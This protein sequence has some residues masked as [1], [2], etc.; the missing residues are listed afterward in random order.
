MRKVVLCHLREYL[1]RSHNPM[2][3]MSVPSRISD[4][5]RSGSLRQSGGTGLGKPHCG[6]PPVP[7]GGYGPGMSKSAT[8]TRD[9]AKLA[10]CAHLPVEGGMAT[11][12]F[13]M[14]L[15]MQRRNTIGGCPSLCN[16]IVGMLLVNAWS[17][18]ERSFGHIVSRLNPSKSGQ[19]RRR[20]SGNQRLVG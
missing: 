2:R 18:R 20:S 17:T 7:N 13:R 8:M 19:S 15:R 6:M 14:R 11:D 4:I 1:D 16:M 3:A 9:F 12:Y 10:I 5:A